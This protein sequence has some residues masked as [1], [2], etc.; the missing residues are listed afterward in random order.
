MG[1][2]LLLFWYRLFGREIVPARPA[3]QEQQMP[4]AAQASATVFLVLRRMRAP[5]IVLITIFAVSVLGLMVIPGLD[6]DGDPYRMGLLDAFYVMSYTATTIGFGEIP[7]PFTEAQRAWVTVVIY[8]SVV[9]WAYALGTLFG[10]LQDRDFRHALTTQRFVRKVR[11]MGEPFLLVAGHGQTGQLLGDSLDVLGRRF[12][13]LDTSSERIAD[14]DRDAY[15]S[16]VPGLAADP[17]DPG[18]L[19]A[20]GL[21]HTRCVGVLA[22]TDDDEANLAVTMAASILRPGVPVVARAL[23]AR[24]A[25]RMRAFGATVI[26]PFDA[27]GDHLRLAVQAPASYQ[28][29]QWLTSLPGE[30]M[31]PR[32][33][34]LRPGRWVVCG[35]GRFGQEV[36]ADLRASGVEVTVVDAG[37]TTSAD[38]DVLVVDGTEV[39]MMAAADVA[40]AAGVIAANDDDVANLALVA[41]ARR[42]HPGVFVVARQNSRPDEAL[43]DAAAID[44]VLVP[45]EVTAHE[46]LAHL[47]SDVLLRFLQQIPARGDAWAERLLARLAARGGRRDLTIWQHD[48]A[49]APSLLSWLSSGEARLGDLLRDP[50]DRDHPLGAVA[51]MV[52]RGAQDVCTPDDDFVLAPGDSLLM[53]GRAGARQDLENIA[54]DEATREYVVHGREVP[55]GWFW[56]RLARRRR[57]AAPGTEGEELVRR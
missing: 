44:L 25:E 57:T 26:N 22:L 39:E 42:A 28:L 17:A 9:G 50:R 56:R 48:L 55:S 29:R 47:G 37:T 19:L 16:D 1:N 23:T 52:V 12:V 46:V 2:P 20:A 21:G 3:P 38:P 45:P 49:A 34:P 5:L 11:R 18:N 6:D 51:L 8:L 54:V 13:V 36:T 41:A 27:F 15:H 30:P 53:A 14:L 32:R 4:T 7:H 40:T 31:P 24:S 43:F 33:A 35:Y 10:L